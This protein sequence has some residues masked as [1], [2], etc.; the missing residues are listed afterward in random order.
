MSPKRPKSHINSDI[1]VARLNGIFLSVGWTIEE[2]SKDYGEDLL[3]RIFDDGQA[4]PYYFYV[5]VKHVENGERLRTRDGRHI[6]YDKFERENLQLWREFSEPVVLVLWDVK[7]DIFYWDIVQSLD[8]PPSEKKTKTVRV[9]IPV[10][11]TLDAFGILRIR[12]RTVRRYEELG[13]LRQGTEVLIERVEELFD[14][15]I[16]YNQ[17]GE[18]IWIQLPNGE[19]DVVYFGRMAKVMDRLLDSTDA[20]PNEMHT[21]LFMLFMRT[22]EHLTNGHALSVV[23]EDGGKV[24]VRSVDEFVRQVR[25]GLEVSQLDS[26]VE[27]PSDLIEFLKES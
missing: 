6:A 12:S 17:T 24:E 15:K 8:K 3:V 22:I 18:T 13:M 14:V 20:D 7:E 11:N 1:S 4:T 9:H 26:D 5:Q 10:D 23:G 2:V 16:T 19:L 27:I 21:K 25:R